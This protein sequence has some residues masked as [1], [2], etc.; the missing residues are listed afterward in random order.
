MAEHE[1]DAAL[2][3]LAEV[4]DHLAGIMYHHPKASYLRLTR[5]EAQQIVAAAAALKA[6]E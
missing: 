6:G 1:V 2:A 3:P 4:A 5:R